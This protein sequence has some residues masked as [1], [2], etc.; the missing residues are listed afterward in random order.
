MRRG[1]GEV[2]GLKGVC[3]R[4]FC[5]CVHVFKILSCDMWKRI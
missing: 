4:Y 3:E 5:Y 1:I 2:L